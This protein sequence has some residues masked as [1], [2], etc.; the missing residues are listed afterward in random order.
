V[1]RVPVSETR[2]DEKLVSRTIAL[3]N[4]HDR[5]VAASLRRIGESIIRDYFGGDVELVRSNDPH[6]GKSLARLAARAQRETDWTEGDF[7]RAVRIALVA[8]TL[9][10]RVVAKIAPSKLMRLSAIEDPAARDVLAARVAAGELTDRQFRVAVARAAG[11]SQRF[12]P[13]RQPA[14]VHL[15]N[16]VERV[17]AQG[18]EAEAFR[19]SEWERVPVAVRA[20][21]KRRLGSAV[22]RLQKLMRSL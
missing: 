3:L 5:A 11:K 18:V 4:R 14:P 1:D 10:E 12:G 6:K 2:A 16:G 15:V 9:D 19:A 13:R 7:R 17:I 8:R 20:G 22:A 21:L